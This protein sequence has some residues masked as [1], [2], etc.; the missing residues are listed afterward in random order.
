MHRD[1]RVFILEQDPY[2]RQW[3]ALLLA[4]DWRTQEVGEASEI[5]QACQALQA[6]RERVDLVLLD[7]GLASLRHSSA[8]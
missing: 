4:R 6:T 8:S 1:A 3:M 5:E 2:A 7:A